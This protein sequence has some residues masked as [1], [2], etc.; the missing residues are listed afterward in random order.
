MNY[1]EQAARHRWALA[2]VLVVM[3]SSVYMLTYSARIESTDT[4][5]MFDATASLVRFGDF[6]LDLTHGERRFWDY[7]TPVPSL[8]LLPVNAEPLQLV[9]AAPLYALADVLPGVGRV[10]AVWLF[11]VMVSGAAVGLFY[12]YALQLGY[13]RSTAFITGGLFGF[14]TILWPYS[15]TFFQEP[16]TLL[17]ILLAAYVIERWRVARSWRWA[18]TVLICLGIAVLARRGSVIT[19]PALMLV[20]F[21]WTDRLFAWRWV[22]W[23]FFGLVVVVAGVLYYNTIPQSAQE[24]G[25]MY[26]DKVRLELIPWE[27]R[28]ERAAMNQG[29]QGYFFSLGGSIWGTSPVILLALP[30]VAL[31]AAQNRM[32]YVVV[33]FSITLSY[34]LGYAYVANFDWFGGL[35]WPPRFMVPVVPFWM[36]CVLPIIEWLQVRRRW[37]AVMGWAGLSLLMGYS[38][39]VQFNAVAYWWGEYA[40]LLPGAAE[41]YTEWA[42][43]LNDP[44]YLRWVMLPRLWGTVPFDFAWVRT[45]AAQVVIPFVGL[46]VVCGWMAVRLLRGTSAGRWATYII[47][48]LPALWVLSVGWSLTQIYEDDLYL[49]FSEGLSDVVAVIREQVPPDEVV[50]IAELGHER[51]FL[52]YGRLPHR[53]ISLPQHPGEQPSPDQPPQVTSP[54]P[55]DLLEN[56][57]PQ[58]IDT[59]VANG[60]QRLWVLADS[61]PFVAWSVLPLERYLS[62]YYYPLSEVDTTGADGLPVRLLSYYAGAIHDPF[63]LRGPDTLTDLRFGDHIQALGVSLPHGATYAAGDV[64]PISLLWRTDAALDERYRVALHLVQPGVGVAASARDGEPGGGFRQMPSWEPGVPVWDNRAMVIPAETAPGTYDLW[65]GVYA[66]DLLP[67]TGAQTAENG[68]LG[69]L[70]LTITVE[71]HN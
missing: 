19:F 28:M 71:P 45:G 12:A 14:G 11:N 61:S 1:F 24:I 47:Y 65:V 22:R 16:I 58:L 69:V 17:L 43:G 20:A 27:E 60:Q 5:F 18:V 54:N 3:V 6:R 35:S 7:D 40:R 59:L 70:P 4:L 13:A 52:N 53:I 41:G 31:L 29:I 25:Q 30:G 37:R 32:R 38:V 39:W 34:A 8:P 42:G 64:L 9:L 62:A 66:T 68:T 56:P 63:T 50:L 26:R 46:V 51:Y 55:T 36:L 57:T 48:A 23:G 49:A 10:H 44:R 21:P 2:V 33:A 67:V 15:K